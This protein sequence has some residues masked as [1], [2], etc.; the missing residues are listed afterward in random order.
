MPPP[1]RYTGDTPSVAAGDGRIG[2][3]VG[4]REIG[5]SNGNLETRSSRARRNS[6]ASRS[7]PAP[8]APRRRARPHRAAASAPS[9]VTAHLYHPAR[10]Q[11][12]QASSCPASASGG[13]QG[14]PS[15]SIGQSQREPTRRRST[16]STSVVRRT[17]AF[18]HIS[19][20]GPLPAHLFGVGDVQSARRLST[21]SVGRLAARSRQRPQLRGVW[22]LLFEGGFR[23]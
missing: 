12:P 3:P 17:T 14:S 6:W 21:A 7:R 9:A 10:A 15:P 23:R 1:W 20:E 2:G 18:D 13:N 11:A 19:S 16:P 4:S 5:C 8:T 22:P